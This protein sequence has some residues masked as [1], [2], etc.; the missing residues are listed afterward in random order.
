[1]AGT[2]SD[3]KVT[4]GGGKNVA[5]YSVTEDSEIKQI[6]RVVPNDSSGK[7]IPDTIFN[8]KVTVT[9]HGTRVKITAG[10]TPV[11]SV[12][13]KALSTNT[14]LIYVGNAT[15]ASTNGFQLSAGESVSFDISDLTNINIDSAVD[16]EGVSYLAIN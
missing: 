8:G 4:E 3:V 7:E 15:V 1:M 10:T 6:Q 5:S 16:G 2:T 11:K 13:I 9:T 12:T 14:G